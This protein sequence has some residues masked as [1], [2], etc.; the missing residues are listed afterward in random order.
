MP[1]YDY[2]A[3]L[4]C[5]GEFHAGTFERMVERRREAWFGDDGSGLIRDQ[6]MRSVFFTEQQRRAWDTNGHESRRDSYEVTLVVFG[7]GE[8]FGLRRQLARLAA[9][10]ESIV[11]RL[12]RTRS[13]SL[14]GIHQLVGE[15]LVPAT[16]RKILFELAAG[17]PDAETVQ[18][19]HDELKRSGIGVG[20]DERGH[21]EELI[22]DSDTLEL[23][24]YRQVLLDPDAGYAPVD[25][26][27]G[28]SSY[29]T[30]SVV[31]G[32]PDGTPPPPGSD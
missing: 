3:S 5:Y 15:A 31:A 24:G 21:R 18:G 22:F 20:R 32:L 4:A 9:D 30:R 23:L 26:I 27:V 29:L 13:L 12:E 8:F 14:H 16:L 11:D 6:K 17:M 7:P 2:I 10:P 25:S 28:Y 1:S 19:A